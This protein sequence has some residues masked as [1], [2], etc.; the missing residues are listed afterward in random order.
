MPIPKAKLTK[1]IIDEVAGVPVGAQEIQGTAILKSKD[2]HAKPPTAFEKRSAL[3]TSTDGHTHL[4]YGLDDAMSGTTTWETM[5][6]SSSYSGHSHPWVRDEQGKIVVG[7]AMGHT[8]E[9]G[10]MSAAIAKSGADKST[11]AI[12]VPHGGPTTATPTEKTA[13][14]TEQE[15][16]IT[17]LTKRNE[18]LERIAK[19]SGVQKAHFDT[20]T[21]DD[22]DAFIA[23]SNTERDTILADVAKRNEEANK[24]VYVS[25]STGDVYRAKDDTRLVDMAKRMDEQHVSI[26]KSNI[27]KR[28]VEVLGGMPGADE[29]HD[30]IIGSVLKSGA[31]QEEI[32]AAIECLKGMK[33]TSS[34]GKRAAGANPGNDPVAGDPWDALQDGLS[35]FCK[36]KNIPDDKAWTEGLDAFAQ[37]PEGAV[38]KRAYDESSS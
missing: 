24:V 12:A 16:K 13:M 27:R 23:K 1:V 10:A 31:K 20:L 19:M 21:G 3:T 34:V 2:P 38:L 33:S 22:A 36:A 17:D 35:T 6:N 18:R 26:E 4:L 5:P 25:K 32:D 7:E 29:V 8:H 30:L 15:N 9:V 28:A 14:P 37:T 11:Q